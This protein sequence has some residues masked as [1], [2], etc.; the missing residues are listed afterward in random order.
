M[1]ETQSH[2]IHVDGL[3]SGDWRPWLGFRLHSSNSNSHGLW[4]DGATLWVVDHA[5]DK[6]YAYHWRGE[7]PGDRRPELD[8]ALTD[9]NGRGAGLWSDGT[10]MWVSDGEDAKIYAYSLD[11]ATYGLRVPALDFNELEPHG[12]ASPNG[13][14]S[15]GSVMWVA[16]DEDKPAVLVQDACFA[17]AGIVVA[18]RHRIRSVQVLAIQIRRPRS[19]RGPFGYDGQRGRDQR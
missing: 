6:L 8:F 2:R 10:T 5:D 3:N 12:N 9:G 14:W 7:N 16:D 1:S 15:N 11:S 17:V 13:I 19:G 18:K 4:S